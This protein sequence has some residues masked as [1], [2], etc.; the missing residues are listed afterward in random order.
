MLGLQQ[1]APSWPHHHVIVHSDNFPSNVGLTK[2]TLKREA[3]AVLRKVL[4]EAAKF[5]II[6]TPV[7]VAG[8]DNELADAISRYDNKTIA[9]WCPHWQTPYNS[10]SLRETGYTMQEITH[11]L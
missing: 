2:Q 4:L 10:L 6:I 3:N 1:W 7:W 8:S 11:L 9:N 5:D